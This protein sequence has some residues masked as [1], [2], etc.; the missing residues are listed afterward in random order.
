MFSVN[1]RWRRAAVPAIAVALFAY[2]LAIR[3]TGITRHLWLFGDQIRDWRIALGPFFQLPL[4]GPATHV[5]GSTIGPAFYW[6]LW[7]LRVVVGPWFENLPHAGAIGQAIL[8][9]V[10]DLLLFAGIRRRTGSTAL[11]VAVVLV[12]ASAP[13]D[14]ALS[15]TIWNPMM[16]VTFAKI[17]LALLLLGWAEH[18]AP[19]A[20]ATAVCAIT[21]VQCHFGG[22]FVAASALATIVLQPLR[23]RDWASVAKRAALVAGVTVVMQLPWILY[24]LRASSGETGTPVGGSLVQ[25]ATGNAAPRIALSARVLA[26]ACSIIEGMPW[27]IPWL[28]WILVPCAVVTAVRHRRDLPML[29]ASIGPLLIA[30]LGVAAWLGGY[31]DYYYLAVMPAA[32]CTVGLASVSIVPRRAGPYVAIALLVV[33]IAIQPPRVRQAFTS[34]RMPEYAPLLR[35]SRAIASRRQPMRRIDAPFVPVGVD[36]NFMYEILGGRLSPDSPWIA[37][38]DPTGNVRYEIAE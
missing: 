4:L 16:A 19:R 14:L 32:V 3:A 34:H 22:I 30:W 36:R 15:S 38:V 28:G 1:P 17:S 10:A 21:A 8:H 29:G 31:H 5:G 27:S 20:A 11:A 37:I 7:I 13:Y 25:I 26:R 2:T 9:S 6:V 35:A 12:V 23:S 24:W 33:A 18:G